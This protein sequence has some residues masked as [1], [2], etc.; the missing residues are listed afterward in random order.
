MELDTQELQLCKILL[1]ITNYSIVGYL[2]VLIYKHI[3]SHY[4]LKSFSFIF[5]VLCTIWLFVRGIFWI[6]TLTESENWTPGLYYFLYWMPVPVEFA[7]FL[8]FPLYFMQI[9]YPVEW[10]QYE[11]LIIPAYG[12]VIAILLSFQAIFIM[13]D[14]M[15]QVSGNTYFFIHRHLHPIS[16]HPKPM[17]LTYTRIPHTQNT[18]TTHRTRRRASARTTRTSSTCPGSASKWTSTT[19]SSA[20]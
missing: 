17:R 14:L 9:I 5:H 4:D 3:S 1:V 11:D 13:V 16:V 8:L 2:L 12:F 7:S 10:R 15:Y 18:K 6:S 19:G 20:P